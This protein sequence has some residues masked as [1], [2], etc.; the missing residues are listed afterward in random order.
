MT[1]IGGC[2]SSG[3]LTADKQIITGT[4]KVIS[5]H[6]ICTGAVSAMIELYDVDSASDIAASNSV[7]ALALKKSASGDFTFAEADMHGVIFKVGL[8][9]DVTYATGSSNAFFWVEY[10]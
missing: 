4:G 7:G 3:K 6:G 5:I 9:A 8:Y 1:G 2:R 10:N